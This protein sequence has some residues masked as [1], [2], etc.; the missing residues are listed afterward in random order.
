MFQWKFLLHQV[1]P[2]TTRQNQFQR[3]ISDI[4]GNSISIDH[5]G[6]SQGLC[7]IVFLKIFPKLPFYVKLRTQVCDFTKNASSWIFLVNF[8][9]RFRRTFSKIICRR[10]LQK[11]S[12]RSVLQKRCSWKFCN[13][14]RKIPVPESLIQ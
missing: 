14:R 2:V 8:V 11:Q 12:F 5:T 1:D 3:Y 13:I 7:R 6:Y 9:K 10:L 4:L